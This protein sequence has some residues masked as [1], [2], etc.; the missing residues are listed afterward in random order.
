V[1]CR[2]HSLCLRGKAH[3][4][5]SYVS[6]L[7]T[8]AGPPPPPGGRG[9]LL[10]DWLARQLGL[11]LPDGGLPATLESLFVEGDQGMPP[12]RQDLGK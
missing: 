5:R 8:Q 3:E 9:L 2:S 1:V 10:G 6:D 11:D 7:V 12:G 4:L